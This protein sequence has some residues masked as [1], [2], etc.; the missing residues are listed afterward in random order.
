MAARRG[1]QNSAW[2]IGV[3]GL[4]TV[5]TGLVS[6]L[7]DRPGFSPNGSTARVTG[8]SARRRGAPRAA[9][10][11][12]VS[13]FDDPV[14][15]AASPDNDLF[16][17]LIGGAEG[18]ARAAVEAAL[19]MGKPVVTAN[20]ALIAT[21]GRA[22]AALAESTGAPLMFE[23]AVM[24]GVP[25][26]KMIREALVADEIESVTGILNGTCNYILTQMEATGRGF[27]E[28]LAEAQALGYAEADPAMDVGGHDAGHKIT[29]LAA[30]A[31]RGAP[32]LGATEVEGIE[33]IEPL[34]IRLAKDLGYR[35][36]LMASAIRSPAGTTVRVHPALTPLDHPL[37]RVD[38]VLNALFIQSRLTGR[39]FIQGAGAGAG[40]TASAVAAD[41]ADVMSGAVRPVFQSPAGGL[42]GFDLV[43]VSAASGRAFVR[44]L[45]R[46]EPGVIAS[47]SETLAEAGVSIDSFLQKPVEGA[48]GVPIVLTTHL[49]PEVTIAR[50]VDAMGA[51]PSLIASPRVIRIARI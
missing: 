38:G 14:A 28:V 45:V 13:W 27:A 47:I 50:A 25:A 17:E 9:A 1:E 46:D 35:I 33:A 24:G 49:A 16:V 34:D 12:G 40:P 29:I 11:A 15:L 3:A 43:P 19:A 37:S 6:L 36:K 20:K 30:L 18:P 8:V 26:V 23:A 44:L 51:L 21:H 5:G 31:F 41:I 10:I 7:A 42:E 32:S 22:L 39:I 4:G 48:G 2:R